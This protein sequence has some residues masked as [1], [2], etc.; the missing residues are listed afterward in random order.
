MLEGKLFVT[1]FDENGRPVNRLRRLG[2]ADAGHVFWPAN[3]DRYVA[4]NTPLAADLVALDPTGQLRP[5][6]SA[7]VEVVRYEYQT[8]IEK[9]EMVSNPD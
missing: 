9:E 4:T 8:V 2:R 5:S 6:A 1:V 7:L 3:T